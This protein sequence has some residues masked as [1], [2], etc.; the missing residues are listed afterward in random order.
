MDAQQISVGRNGFI[1]SYQG[2]TESRYNETN[3]NRVKVKMDSRELVRMRSVPSSLLMG[4][5][6]VQACG[7]M[8]QQFCRP[9]ILNWLYGPVLALMWIYLREEKNM[10]TPRRVQKWP[11]LFHCG[12]PK[13]DRALFSIGR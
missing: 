8:L 3:L 5:R 9:S 6:L 7:K 10:L 4:C 1:T 2:N 12:N 13:V 11:E